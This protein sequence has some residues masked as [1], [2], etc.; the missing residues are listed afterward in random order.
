MHFVLITVT[1][2]NQ[3]VAAKRQEFFGAL[4]GAALG[5]FGQDASFGKVGSGNGGQG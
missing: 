4:I 5:Q 2:G 3:Q 1:A